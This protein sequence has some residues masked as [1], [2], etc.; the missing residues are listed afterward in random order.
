MILHGDCI[1]LMRHLPDQSVDMIFCDLPYGKT[2]CSWDSPIPMADL[3]Q[4]YNRIIK[5]DRAIV[6]TASQPF[7]SQLVMSN[8]KAFKYSMV[9]EKSKASGFLNAKIRPMAAHEDILVFSK[10]RVPYYPQKSAGEAYDKGVRKQQT[11]DDIYGK[12]SRTRVA[13]EGERYPRSVIYFKTAESEGK[14]FHKTQK[15]LALC[16]YLIS[17]YT[18][19]RETV[20]DNCMGSGSAGIAAMKLGRKFIGM[21]KD[22]DIFNI[23]MERMYGEPY[24][25]D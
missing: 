3:W 10:G 7:S 9:W 17:T 22:K 18:Q 12:Y 16:E 19:P 23:A 5:P 2:K 8:P 24:Y 21:E 1:Q 4:Q 13:S 6:F 14:T 11:D 25:V 20:L 15:P